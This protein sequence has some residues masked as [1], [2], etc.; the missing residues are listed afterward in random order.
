MACRAALLAA[1]PS[2]CSALAAHAATLRDVSL[3]DAETKWLEANQG[4]MEQMLSPTAEVVCQEAQK[5]SECY[6][7]VEYLR[8]QGFEA[9][10]TWYPGYTSRSSFEEVQDMLYGLEKSKCPKPCFAKASP[11]M[12]QAAE[13]KFD[14]KDTA[15]GDLCF[16]SIA[17]LK[18]VGLAQ[19]PDWYPSLRTSSSNAAIQAELHRKGKADC[20][21]PCTPH[22]ESE[23]PVEQIVEKPA[24]VAEKIEEDEDCMDAQVGSPCY[25]DVA[26]GVAEGIRKHPIFYENLSNSSNFKDVQ[27]Y[28]YLNNRSFCPRPC[29][30]RRVSLDVL[31]AHPEQLKEKK[32]IQDMSIDEL[33]AYL[34]GD[35]DGYVA[36]VFQSQGEVIPFQ[37]RKYDPTTTTMAQEAMPLPVVDETANT[38]SDSVTDANASDDFGF[39][40]EAFANAKQRRAAPEV[41][42][43]P[44]Q[45]A[46]GATDAVPL[47]PS[48]VTDTLLRDVDAEN[49]TADEN[50]TAGENS[51]A[52]EAASNS[53][54]DEAVSNVSVESLPIGEEANGTSPEEAVSAEIPEA[55]VVPST[56]EQAV[57]KE[58][59][60]AQVVPS[61]DA[62]WAVMNCLGTLRGVTPENFADIKAECESVMPIEGEQRGALQKEF[63]RYFIWAQHHV[64]DLKA[65]RETKVEVLA[66]AEANATVD[67][68]VG[69]PTPTVDAVVG[70]PTSTGD[71][72]VGEST[73]AV[74]AIVDEPTPMIGA[75]G[76]GEMTASDPQPT[77]SE[78]VETPE[79]MEQRLRKQVMEELKAATT[80]T[81]APHKETEEEMR[82]RIK[83]EVLRELKASSAG[84]N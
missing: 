76:E 75:D 63:L 82:E 45:E 57:S 71:A 8:L 78:H 11:Q 35:W 70:E 72:V 79:E 34:N 4:A 80:T 32:R 43:P 68:V 53:T 62:D 7:A 41:T 73:P 15:E 65:E 29:P 27:E 39:D 50:S 1:L 67:S 44:P 13:A 23:T 83:A 46:V 25:N 40:F 18:E 60:E 74:D 24:E 42:F 5:G 77:A 54:A 52:D 58:F 49:S 66:T 84:A 3:L 51:I 81:V 22:E 61:S 31:V 17:W 21:L 48:S 2:T 12:R 59:P 55:Q 36:K 28:L 64:Q 33:S 37:K 19:H 38:S 9:H 30:A 20:R 56:T 47:A 10:P 6:L 16:A 69:E 14:C 26:Y